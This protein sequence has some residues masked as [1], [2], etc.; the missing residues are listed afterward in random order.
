MLYQLYSIKDELVA[1]GP[2]F[3]SENDS[4][5]SRL[6]LNGFNIDNSMYATRPQDYT[7][8]RI[9]SYETE[10]G[11]IDPCTPQYVISCSDFK[12][13]KKGKK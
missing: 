12:R 2:V 10:T 6:L 13:E 7:L 8:Y 3:V 11:N 4:T 9:G 1:F 5:A